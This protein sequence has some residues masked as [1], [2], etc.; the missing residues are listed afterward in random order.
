MAVYLDTNVIYGWRTFGE[1]DRL[2]LSTAADQIGQS[3]VIPELVVIEAA[4]HYQRDLEAA[5]DSFDRAEAQLIELFELEYIHTEPQPDPDQRMIKWRERLDEMCE[6]IPTDESDAVLAL[7]R[8]VQ[9]HPPARERV[10]GKPGAGARDAAIWLSILRDH[11]ERDEPGYFLTK[12]TK[13][14][15]DDDTLKPFLLE[16]L[17]DLEHPLEVRVGVEGL[18][19]GLGT[20]V[21]AA[22]VDPAFVTRE[23]FTAVQHGLADSLIV[24]RVVFSSLGAHRFRTAVTAGEA[25]RVIR[26]QRFAR[27]EASILMVDAEWELSADCLFQELPAEDENRWGVVRD[28]G[29]TGRLQV[30]IHE[31][32]EVSSE[33]Q[34]I[35]AQL[36]SNKS[37]DFMEDGRLLIWG[38]PS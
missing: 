5:I 35:A 7:K 8:E 1:L 30:Y 4:A 22:S 38:P 13:D 28:V 11:R 27:D 2:A 9:G 3:I 18:L 19:K 37:A 23:A 24:P 31:E 15:F 17:V 25:L 6:V 12:N 16:D 32:S 33:G 36:S 26:A 14:F 29:L 21:R 34:L 20:S 10:Q